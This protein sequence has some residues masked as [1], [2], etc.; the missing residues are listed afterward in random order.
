M[1]KFSVIV[2]VYNV[3][4]Y[5]EECVSSVIQQTYKGYEL[6]LLD[7][8]STDKS[9]TICD[10]LARRYPEK[11]I[12][13]HK[14]NQ[15]PLATRILGIQHASGDI[16]VF[17]DS[18]DG[19]RKDAL[20]MLACCFQ[21][22]N[23]D[24]VLFDAGI[25]VSYSSR[26]ITHFLDAN[27]VFEKNTKKI[28]YQKLIAYQI[29]NSVCL[30]AIKKNRTNFPGYF[31]DFIDVKHGED[32]MMS[33]CF[34][35]NCQKV[36]YLDEG[37][38][39][40]RNRQGSAIHSFNIKRTECLKVVHTEMEKFIDI[41]EMPELKPL[42]NARKVKGWVDTVILLMDNKH[43]ISTLEYQEYLKS[44]AQDDYF[45]Y[46]YTAMDASYLPNAHRIMAN[47]LYKEH[48][49]VLAVL[50]GIKRLRKHFNKFFGTNK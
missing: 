43:S 8:G 35:N 7:D 34:L 3:E 48:Y 2:P 38:Y 28:L 31:S 44:M 19:L 16:I 37:L 13:I 26:Q 42:H 18:D 23:C 6:L 30:K 14:E 9:G 36:V 25:C 41:W 39:F 4:D 32:L 45:C 15:G 50:V 33:A 20:E 12:V 49:A 5:L 29:P 24:M 10:Q 46:A 27:R 22:E 1:Q 11:I 21:T 47:L 17:L 40:Y